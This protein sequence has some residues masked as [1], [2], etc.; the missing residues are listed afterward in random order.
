MKKILFISIRLFRL[1][2]FIIFYF[3]ELLLSGVLLARDI[4]RPKKTFTHGII[5]IGIDISSPTA[6][7]TMVNLVSMTP[8][9]LIIELT[10]DHRYLYVHVMYLEDPERFE[11]DLKNKFEKK[12]KRIFE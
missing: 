9:S 4:I 2:L 1:L 5:R 6:L 12:I 10:P 3:K 7:M 8:G 11:S